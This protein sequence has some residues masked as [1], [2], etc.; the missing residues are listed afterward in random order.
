MDT[1]MRPS[2]TQLHPA[3][4][5]PSLPDVI[6]KSAGTSPL[7][8]L[9]EAHKPLPDLGSPRGGTARALNERAPTDGQVVSAA[10]AKTDIKFQ[11]GLDLPLGSI[12]TN[13]GTATGGVT[14]NHDVR[15]DRT[16]TQV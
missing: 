14:L 1:V 7:T 16:G 10:S 9:P 11:V 6:M 13:A 5:P 2:T 15:V 8:K 3:F 4:V 12:R